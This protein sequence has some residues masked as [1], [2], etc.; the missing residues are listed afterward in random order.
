MRFNIRKIIPII[1]FLFG[2]FYIIFSLSIIEKKMIGDVRDWDPG[3]RAMPLGVGIVIVLSSLYLYF[4]ESKT[5]TLKNIKGE[6][7]EN[8]LTNK[9]STQKLIFL[10]II[11]SVL[12]I[13]VLRQIG[14]IICT[15]VILY[16]L[17]VIF[18]RGDF[19]ISFFLEPI[20]PGLLFSIGYMVMVYS[21]G[22]WITRSLFFLG[23]N[24][25]IPILKSQ[26]FITGF[27][28][29]GLI[30][31]F[32]FTFFIMKKIIN[33]KIFYQ[34]ILPAFISVGITEILYIVFKQIFWV[35]L[36]KG[37]IFW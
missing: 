16:M 12:Y 14:F 8:N 18:S 29:M 19:Q 32:T 33:Q 30:L 3:S 37:I 21:I 26:L 22:R 25:D 7:K 28:F 6:R 24:S 9:N 36:A 23:R 13:L 5:M 2:I 17:I 27:T 1:F 20:L 31:L 34:V 10:T 35:D 15:V 11:L 4:K